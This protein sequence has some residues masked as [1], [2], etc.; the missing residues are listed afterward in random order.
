MPVTG[1]GD[2]ALTLVLEQARRLGFLGKAAISAQLDHAAAF[3][4][5]IAEEPEAGPVLDLGSGGG[6]PG[7]VVAVRRPDLG[8][9]LLDATAKKTEFLAWAVEALDLGA[10]VEVVQS[11]AEHAGHADAYRARFGTVV[12]RSFAR[13]AVTAESAAPL[14]RVGGRLIVSDPPT[15]PSGA[16]GSV[17]W[18]AAGL[19]EVGLAPERAVTA[20]F[21]L[22][23][24]RQVA[25]CPTRYAR[26]AGIPS[27]RP[28]F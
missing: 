23:V 1:G 2:A 12:A 17:R 8:V 16:D 7:L 19:A 9:V 15:G 21:H 11:R 3:V 24:L 4:D 6:L 22:T 14:L 5:A 18:P 13:P 20:P 10:R 28:L 26:K 27:K 25:P